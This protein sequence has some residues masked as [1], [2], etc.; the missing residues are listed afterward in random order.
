MIKLAINGYGRI[1]RCVLRALYESEYRNDFEVVAINELADINTAAY[2]TQFDTT[3]GRFPFDVEVS[4]DHLNIQNAAIQFFSESNPAH[5][6]WAEL[7]VDV[8][9]ECS[10][11]IK[12]R[13]AAQGH[14]DAGAKKVIFS[15][16]ADVEVDATIVCGVNEGALKAGH[17]IVSAASCTSNCCV[18]II[19]LLDKNFG[20]EHGMITTIHSAMNDQA[21]IDGYHLY[22][23]AQTAPSDLRR[24]RS[25]G[26]SIIPVDTEL[27]KGIERVLPKFQGKFEAVHMRVPT[28]NVSVI[29]LTVQLKQPV[30]ATDVNAVL[31]EAA[32][33]NMSSVL[34]YTEE[35]HVSCDFNHDARSAVVDGTQTR[36]VNGGL[37][38][39]FVWFD[40]EWGF[41]NRMLDVAHTLMKQ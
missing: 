15:Q 22:N 29:D 10:G 17:K 28:H 37:V 7:G 32:D 41:A 35:P 9:M 14:I 33:G 27:A 11:A 16:P 26:Q 20:I 18:P 24:T 6:P 2:L 31:K 23:G 34:G 5:L 13:A 19:D 3:H 21:V 36:A 4:G 25:A 40:N 8:V 12:T 39:V 38:K 1:G 30:S